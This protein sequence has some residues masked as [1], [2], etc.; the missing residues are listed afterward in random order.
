MDTYNLFKYQGRPLDAS[1]REI[2][3]LHLHPSSTDRTTATLSVKDLASAVGAFACVSYVWG[4]PNKTM[5]IELDD[6]EVLNHMDGK[7]MQNGEGT[8]EI[9]LI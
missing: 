5:P 2:R 9:V 7:I 6:Q 1:R 4:D 3:L 8:K